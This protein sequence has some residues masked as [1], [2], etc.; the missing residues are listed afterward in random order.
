MLNKVRC[1]LCDLQKVPGLD[2]YY[3]K[4]RKK[5]T[6]KN[7]NYLN[8]YRFSPMLIKPLLNSHAEK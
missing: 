5:K 3:K 6:V 2:P 4:S 7:K 8:H 1:C